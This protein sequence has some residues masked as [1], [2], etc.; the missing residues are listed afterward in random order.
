MIHDNLF[1]ATCML[2][3]CDVVTGIFS[4]ILKKSLYS[5]KMKNGILKKG[6]IAC[7]IVAFYYFNGVQ[8]RV[9]LAL[10]INLYEWAC[11]LSI[12]SDLISIVENIETAVPNFLPRW[13]TK[14]LK[15]VQEDER[16]NRKGGS[17][18]GS[19]SE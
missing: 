18:G 16:E 15:G 2:M 12:L 11:V 5:D 6:L 9:G 1:I 8:D 4:A 7:L 19:D 3:G 10:P 14:F 17:V 13:L